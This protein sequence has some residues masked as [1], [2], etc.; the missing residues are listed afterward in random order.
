[1]KTNII[2]KYTNMKNVVNR[3]FMVKKTY[4]KYLCAVLLMIGT[5][6]PANAGVKILE[7]TGFQAVKAPNNVTN[8]NN[9]WD[10]GY[11]SDG[12]FGAC[13]TTANGVTISSSQMTINTTNFAIKAGQKFTISV[14]SGAIYRIVFKPKD[15]G[16][17]SANFSNSNGVWG[18]N[19]TWQCA[20]SYWG[21]TEG[22]SSVTFTNNFGTNFVLYSINVYTY[23]DAS[24]AEASFSPTSFNV[25]AGQEE[26][27][28]TTFT[29][30]LGTFDGADSP[31]NNAIS[32]AVGTSSSDI[33]FEGAS[34]SSYSNGSS[35][36]I[37]IYP[38]N[39]GDYTGEIML[40]RQTSSDQANN[41]H[42]MSI[43]ADFTVHVND[44][45]TNTPTL[46]FATPGT[47]NKKLGDATFTN[48]ATS[49][50]GTGTTRQTINYSSSDP[51]VATV[52]SS[53]QVTLGS[54]CGTTT[55]TASVESNGTYCSASTTYTINLSGYNVTFHYPACAESSPANLTNQHGSI[56]LETAMAVDGYRF[57][58][59]TD[60]AV[61]D[62]ASVTPLYTS[63]VSVSAD[64]DLYAVYTKTSSTF[65][66]VD[67]GTTAPEAGEYVIV[68][69][70]SAGLTKVLTADIDAKYK[71][72]ANTKDYTITDVKTLSCQ[73]EACIWTITAVSG[74]FTIRNNST[75]KYLGAASGDA[76]K[77][78]QKLR[79]ESSTGE[80][81][82]WS[83]SRES[84]KVPFTTT[85]N[86]RN[87]DGETRKNLMCY[88]DYYAFYS[89]GTSPYLFKRASASGTYTS[90]PDCN[91]KE[92]KVTIQ[93]QSEG[94]VT[95]S[96]S[97]NG[98]WANPVLSGLHGSETITITATPDSYHDF[99]SW[100]V[101]SGG[102]TLSST[103][104]ATATFTMPTSD[105]VIRPNFT[106]KSYT[107]TYKDKGD[108]P[109]S[110]SAIDGSYNTYT[111]GVGL[112]LPEVTKDNWVF[113]G[114]YAETDCSGSRVNSLSTTDNGDKT[115]Y[116]LWM[117]YSDPL[118]WC[119]EPEV[120]LT[121]D[122]VYVTSTN[123]KSI[124][125]VNTLTLN[126]INLVP[127]S[128]VRLSTPA[129]SGIMF[130]STRVKYNATTATIDFTADAGGDIT[131]VPVYVHYYPAS[132][133]SG[134]PADVTVTAT[135]QANT[136]YY[137]T[138]DVHVR[139]MPSS[140]V[141]ATKVGSTWYAL[142]A[143]I[144]SA[145]NPEGVLVEV[146]E[147]DWTA[148]GPSTLAYKL[149]PVKTTT[150]NADLYSV[151]GEKLR[152]SGISNKGLYGSTS[153]NTINNYAVID[154]I[155]KDPGVGAD[156]SYEWAVTTTP[157]GSTWKYVLE[158]GTD[159]DLVLHKGDK[160]LW[161]TYGDYATREVYILPLTEITPFTMKVVE[162]YPTKV[163]VYSP[164]D[165][166][167][168]G[169]AISINGTPVVSPT[170]TG[171]GN[172]L[173]EIGNLPLE[174]NPAKTLTLS[175]TAATVDYATSVTIP[176]I[177]SRVTKSVVDPNG[178]K[179]AD[180]CP[181]NEP[182]A[183]LTADVYNY[184]D[185]V[186]RDGA[187]LTL[188]GT[189]AQNSFFDV[190]IYPTSK[191]SVPETNA[192]EQNNYIGVH[193]L[194]FFGGI[195]EIY[196][197]SSYTI[198]K[199]GV[200]ELSLKGKCD[201]KTVTTINYDMRVDDSQM[202]SLTV[203]YDVNLTDITYW[204][205]TS[206]GKLGTKLWI[207][208]Y[209]G[210]ARAN[211]DM[212]LTWVYEVNFESK[213]EEA[214][215]KQGTGYTIS[216]DKQ[217][218]FG[219]GA[220][221]G[222]S[223]IRLPM[224]SNFSGTAPNN[225]EAAK[226]VP[227][228]AY[229]NTQGVTVS[230]NHKGWNLVGN[231]YMVSISGGEPGSQLVV[232]KLVESGTG[233][234]NWDG[235]TYPYRYVTIP[236]DDG[237]DY[238]QM[239]FKDATLRPFKNF[240]VQID[241]TTEG[242][243]LGFALASR[244]D[245]PA[246]FLQVAEREVEFE[247]LLANESRK[248]NMGL[249]IAEQYTTGYEINADLEKM[250]GT[251]SVYSIL[252]GYNLAYNALSP[253]DAKEWIPVGYVAPIAGEYTFSLDDNSNLTE[254]DHV[255]LT[256]YLLNKTVDLLEKEYSFSTE[257][258]KNEGRFAINVLLKPEPE[259]PITTGVNHLDSD[260]DV[261]LKFIYQDKMYIL[262]NGIIYDAVGKK[263]NEINK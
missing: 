108:N 36:D 153:T 39:A 70:Y 161:G 15:S 111:Y 89:S 229:V 38:Y 134:S 93:Q 195:D 83:I 61:A 90:N 69:S 71:I 117:Q 123:G 46:A 14:S 230:D 165:L 152:F 23:R 120:H 173:Y 158:A 197:G 11:A 86:K 255:Y 148:K 128:T 136:D 248:D 44:G 174:S 57:A 159:K 106:A 88:G 59:W 144:A 31:Y 1:M 53:G 205:G 233:P 118:A 82:T 218:G 130:S 209:D 30:N 141:I 107:I 64:I 246:R 227:V 212:A 170:F 169:P 211:K 150:G 257:K 102:V 201:H 216:A 231:P 177:I 7:S 67:K 225:V 94:T 43:W 251:M 65:T 146:N 40:S 189:K 52:N 261:P 200:P 77:S 100:T 37:N 163:L 217:S 183:S 34:A 48:A 154:A 162:W 68:S 193:S 138:Q 182:F 234:W 32:A 132:E 9:T 18:G 206:M 210:Q 186:V 226:T 113:M 29:T 221:G 262:R 103:T 26:T 202:Y 20:D 51:E 45:C 119:P 16:N 73:E 241:N 50:P 245:A 203:P 17:I 109:Y 250:I 228:T 175:Y 260:S 72:S 99:S 214:K 151:Q 235:E 10:P 254:V 121:G 184:T 244:Q 160:M 181:L 253:D 143:N 263:V 164:N 91:A 198:N 190:T 259:D 22:K 194:T 137:S 13:S 104:T 155:D 149:W 208:A 4:L 131:D 8:T 35:I 213:F 135:Y 222:Y 215:L 66:L 79:L 58:G 54:K 122:N 74:G 167:T 95:A 140:F 185:L 156:G 237:T 258:G 87:T 49:T 56:N 204:D 247:V 97:A 63:T 12:T 98:T 110:G 96:A 75:G 145:S 191:I 252:G 199:Y 166:K 84:N 41:Y 62:A 196:D 207:S 224:K 179:V 85:N 47:I 76:G 3:T 187:V 172:N 27:K 256:D 5:C 115:F 133:G 232:G 80:Y 188:N 176:I 243:A 78:D 178:V 116:A 242:N 33:E 180:L 6:A 55:I 19:N 142:P 129:S 219:D 101:V 112:T 42:M 60:H 2:A 21:F 220:G 25:T 249:L 81:T 127:G 240:F 124:M 125:A 28:H 192:N 239:K 223:I 238:Y 168:I 105:V 92:Y 171:K 147:S 139:N 24:A 157:I 236:F 114:W 126:A